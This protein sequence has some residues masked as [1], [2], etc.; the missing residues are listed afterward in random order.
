[1]GGKFLVIMVLQEKGSRKFFISGIYNGLALPECYV[2]SRK[3]KSVPYT[4]VL[5]R[6]R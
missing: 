4:R 5:L 1:M 2:K 3:S 6:A